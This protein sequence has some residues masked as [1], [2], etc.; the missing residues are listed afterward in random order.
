M[1]YHVQQTQPTS[2]KKQ[3]DP[4][5][6]QASERKTHLSY[7]PQLPYSKPQEHYIKKRVGEGGRNKKEHV[8]NKQKSIHQV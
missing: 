7:P 1:L 3:C 6:I 4:L 2:R 8:Y 5:E